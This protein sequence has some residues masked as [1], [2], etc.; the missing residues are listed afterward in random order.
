I[1]VDMVGVQ[2]NPRYFSEPEEFRPS[3]WYKSPD[4]TASAKV[5]LSESEEYTAFSVGPYL[6]LDLPR[7]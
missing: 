5:D 7:L 2:Y 6:I 3:R 4:D 1:V